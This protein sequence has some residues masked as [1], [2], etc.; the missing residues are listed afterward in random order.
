MTRSKFTKTREDISSLIVYLEK[1]GAGIF[2]LSNSDSQKIQDERTQEMLK[3]TR[4]LKFD[5]VRSSLYIGYKLLWVI[6]LF[7]EGKKFP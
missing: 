7:L 1:F 4:A 2:E 3:K 6:T 5:I